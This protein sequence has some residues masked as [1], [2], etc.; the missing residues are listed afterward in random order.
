MGEE[1]MEQIQEDIQKIEVYKKGSDALKEEVWDDRLESNRIQS[2]VVDQDPEV[3]VEEAAADLRIKIE[4]RKKKTKEIK[5]EYEEF[6]K[7]QKKRYDI[8]LKT[9]REEAEKLRLKKIKEE[10]ERK[11]KEAEMK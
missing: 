1:C 6:L 8:L 3:N 11:K 4:I 9:K 2:A 5:A 7:D 10:E